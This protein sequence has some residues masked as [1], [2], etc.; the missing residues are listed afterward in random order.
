MTDLR[1][2]L[3]SLFGRLPASGCWLDLPSPEAAEIAA[4]AGADFG[5]IDLEHGPA[6][7]ETAGRMAVALRAGGAAAIARPPERSEA[8]IKRLLDSGAHGVLIPMVDT[9]EQAAEAASWVRYP[10]LGV[11]G[12]AT[13]VIRA[14]GWG[15][16]AERYRAEWND[17]AFL[18]VQIESPEALAAA[19]EIAAV[20]GVDLLFFGPADFSARSGFADGAADP[21]AFEAFKAMAGAAHGAGKA[22]GSVAFPA[23]GGAALADA[24]CAMIAAA[25]DVT[26]LREGIAT[27]VASAWADPR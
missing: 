21:R 4:V 12:V 17:R 25:S 26:A 18:A 1:A 13:T 16:A 5:V 10:P 9:P 19:P 3:T 23:A 8:W 6:S 11:R 15:G 24:G 14:A 2:K 20:D 7:V 22:A 27:A